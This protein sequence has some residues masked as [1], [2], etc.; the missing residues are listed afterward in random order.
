MI[1]YDFTNDSF[2]DAVGK[3]GGH[4]PKNISSVIYDYSGQTEPLLN[5]FRSDISKGQFCRYAVTPLCRYALA[6]L[7]L[8]AV[9]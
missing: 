5:L 7:Y 4:G 8:Y 6:P 3:G 9:I 1:I 2:K